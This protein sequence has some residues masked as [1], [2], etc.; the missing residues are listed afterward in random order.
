M[1]SRSSASSASGKRAGAPAKFDLI[2]SFDG[3]NFYTVME[4]DVE[5]TTGSYFDGFDQYKEWRLFPFS[6]KGAL[7]VYLLGSL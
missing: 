1:R 4:V 5:E 6:S 2:A 3:V 7:F